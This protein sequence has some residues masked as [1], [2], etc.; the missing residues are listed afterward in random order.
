MKIIDLSLLGKWPYVTLRLN[1]RPLPY[2]LV[3]KG[4]LLRRARSNMMPFNLA[5]EANNLGRILDLRLALLLV[6]HELLIVGVESKSTLVIWGF[7]PIHD[8][9]KCGLPFMT[10][11]Q[12]F[13]QRS[14]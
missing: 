1:L 3:T 2:L 10:L 4:L 7:L 5:L 8:L 13:L 12:V 6:K 11:F 14:D 9:V